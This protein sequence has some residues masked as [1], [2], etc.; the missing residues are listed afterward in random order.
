MVPGLGSFFTPFAQIPTGLSQ[1]DTIAGGGPG[2]GSPGGLG[3]DFLNGHAGNGDL[4]GNPGRDLLQ[5]EQGNDTLLRHV[6]LEDFGR[7]NHGGFRLA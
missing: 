1:S 6:Q 4:Y 3:H 2:N 5:V 7:H